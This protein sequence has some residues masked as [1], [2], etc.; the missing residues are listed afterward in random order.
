MYK[1]QFWNTSGI[2]KHLDIKKFEDTIIAKIKLVKQKKKMDTDEAVNYIK[3][4]IEN[5]SLVLKGEEYFFS[6]RWDLKKF[7]TQSNSFD[8]FT[9]DNFKR[10]YYLRKKSRETSFIPENLKN[11]SEKYENLP[12]IN[13]MNMGGENE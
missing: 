3:K 8:R 11:S 5:Y 1:R 4:T 9:P 13:I 6:Y 12:V 7:F 10:E 2:I